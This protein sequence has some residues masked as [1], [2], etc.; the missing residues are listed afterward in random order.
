MAITLAKFKLQLVS[1][2]VNWNSP[3][4]VAVNNFEF[5]KF[6][7]YKFSKTLEKCRKW[8]QETSTGATT[9]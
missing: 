3:K 6:L 5:L 8:S 9:L 1:L 2:C 7:E 4:E